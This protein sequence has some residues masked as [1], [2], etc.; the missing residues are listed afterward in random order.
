MP[1]SFAAPQL[2]QVRASGD[3]QPPQ[4]LR[5]AALSNPHCGHVITLG[6]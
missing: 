1:G 5:P 3:P 6:S 4:N 2:G